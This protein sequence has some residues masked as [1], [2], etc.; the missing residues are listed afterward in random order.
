MGNRFALVSV[1][2][3]LLLGA[4][5]LLSAPPSPH[6]KT[7]ARITLKMAHYPSKADKEA[8]A[9]IVSDNK[10]RQQERVLAAALASF[11]HMPA[12]ADRPKLQKITEDASATADEKD[13]A[14]I[15]LNMHHMPDAKAKKRLEAMIK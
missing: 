13:L 14:S 10:A 5:P 6:L 11:E 7:M 1:C 4:G 8:L 2:M 12:E 15:I 3:A 9:R